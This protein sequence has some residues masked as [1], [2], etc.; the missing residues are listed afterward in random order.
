MTSFTPTEEQLRIISAVSET[1]DNLIIEA[2][3]GAAKTTTLIMLAEAMP[4]ARILSLA[5]NAKIRDEMRERMPANVDAMT[6][7]GIGYSAWRGYCNT[8]C[9]VEKR[10]NYY[11]LRAEIEKLERAEQKEAWELFSETLK[12]IGKTKLMGYIGPNQ[13]AGTRP[14]ISR[15]DF[16][17]SALDFEATPLQEQLIDT[18]ASKS[19]TATLRGELDFDD[20]LLGPAICGVSFE[21]YDVVLVDEAQDLSTINHVLLQKICRFRTRLIAVGDPYQAIYGFRGADENS[22]AVLRE[23]F[24]AK[25]FYL[26]VSFRCPQ[27]IVENA[28]WRAP[29]MQWPDWAKPGLILRPNMWSPSDIP[30]GAAIICRNNAPL[31]T[32]AIRLLRAGRFP[33]FAGRD[34]LKNLVTRMRKLGKDKLPREKALAAIKPWLEEEKKRQRNHDLLRDIAECMRIFLNETE[35]LGD[36]IAFVK[37][38]ESRGGRIYLMTGHRAKGLE[39]DTVFF[40]DHHLCRKTGQDPNIRYVIETRAQNRLVYIKSDDFIKDKKGEPRENV[41]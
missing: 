5:F 1:R 9:R 39:F 37:N 38:L 35:T 11:L 29:D 18:V 12:A 26:T 36:A 23:A 17:A 2:R 7:N 6:L 34:V 16:Y 21:H 25:T 30:D 27:A 19:W 13:S 14:L 15:A 3:A 8:R 41:A 22:M 10:K 4:D 32:T 31:F 40:L 28:R 24:A 33:E 20:M